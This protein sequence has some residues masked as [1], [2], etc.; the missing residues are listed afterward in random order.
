M[1]TSR[2]STTFRLQCKGGKPP[3][4]YLLRVD[5]PV[6]SGLAHLW[7]GAQV[8]GTSHDEQVRIEAP[9][10]QRH[11]DVVGVASESRHEHPSSLNASFS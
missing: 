9:R 7:L 5:D 8:V 3:P 11:I 1:T 2:N 4:A 10:C 6:G